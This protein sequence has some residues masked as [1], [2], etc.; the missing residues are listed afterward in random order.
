MTAKAV[1]AMFDGLLYQALVSP[2]PPSRTDIHPIL[3][4]LLH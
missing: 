1:T 3:R 2:Q 4:L